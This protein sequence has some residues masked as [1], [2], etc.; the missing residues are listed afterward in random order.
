MRSYRNTFEEVGNYLFRFSLRELE[1]TAIGSECQ[2]IAYKFVNSV[3]WKGLEK[4]KQDTQE[5]EEVKKRIEYKDWLS[6]LGASQHSSSLVVCIMFKECPS[7]QVRE[8]LEHADYRITI[9]PK[10]PYTAQDE[11]VTTGDEGVSGS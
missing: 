10:N 9:L 4:A 11:S 6:D 8:F 5:H 7:L 3:Y 1:K 2:M